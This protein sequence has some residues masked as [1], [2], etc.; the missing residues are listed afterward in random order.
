[1]HCV[2][3]VKKALEAVDGV[4]SADVNLEQADAA[5]IG[6]APMEELI[7]AVTEAGYQAEAQ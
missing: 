1:M 3:A 4:E 7:S 6:D 5:V 2:G